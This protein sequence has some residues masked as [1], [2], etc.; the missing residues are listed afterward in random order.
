MA[1]ILMLLG[2]GMGG[3]VRYWLSNLN[4]VWLAGHVPLGTLLAN[5]TGSAL[6]AWGIVQIDPYALV[7]GFR[8]QAGVVVAYVMVGASGGLTTFSTLV[9]ETL[10]L[11]ASGAARSYSSRMGLWLA[12][13][14]LCA[15][16]AGIGYALA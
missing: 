4:A 8:W 3:V 6:L 10:N 5:I 11:D 7:A 15:I 16:A 14:I 1:Y 12:H 9:A 13:I 2:A